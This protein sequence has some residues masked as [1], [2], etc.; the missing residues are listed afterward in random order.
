MQVAE[1]YKKLKSLGYSCWLDI[2]Q[3]GAGDSLYNKIDAG[4]RSCDVVISCVTQKYSLSLNC[5]R[6]VSLATSVN[7]PII[8]L[9]LEKMN[10]PPAGPMSMPLCQLQYLDFSDH[11]SLVCG[12]SFV[13]LLTILSQHGV[14]KQESLSKKVSSLGTTMKAVS[15]MKGKSKKATSQACTLL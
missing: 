7:K 13:V 11:T 1:L 9:L 14:V 5:R 2:D 8:P 3:M 6:E 4:I 12:Q 15:K 10:W